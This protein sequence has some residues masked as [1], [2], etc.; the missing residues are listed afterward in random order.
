MKKKGY[1][2]DEKDVD[3]ILAIH[4]A[5]NEQGWTKILEWERLKGCEKPKLKEFRGRPNDLTPR[6]RF[7]HLIGYSLPFD[8]HDWVVDSDG[9]DARYVIDFYS[10]H[11]S[12]QE[13]A[14]ISMHLDVR[15]ALDSLSPLLLRLRV[16][17][18]GMR[19]PPAAVS[20]MLQPFARLWKGGSAPL[21]ATSPTP[22]VDAAVTKG[23]EDGGNNA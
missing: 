7:L 8:R 16:G 2:P 3:V 4:N 14:P 5:V 15:P 12:P 10:G 9:T 22:K 1:N 18:F 21:P 23:K 20:W 17:L 13:R 6:A 11:M 19:S